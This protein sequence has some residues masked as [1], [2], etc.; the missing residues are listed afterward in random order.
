MS[1]PAHYDQEHLAK[2]IILPLFV[3]KDSRTECR[4]I[5]SQDRALP[6]IQWA[7]SLR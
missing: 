5:L 7:G 3:M 1:K 4:G 2:V 6:V